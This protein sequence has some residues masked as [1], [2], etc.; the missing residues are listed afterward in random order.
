[1]YSINSKHGFYLLKTYCD[2][3]HITGEDRECVYNKLVLFLQQIA[4]G[5]IHAV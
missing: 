1:M 2:H 5:L 3:W 4:F